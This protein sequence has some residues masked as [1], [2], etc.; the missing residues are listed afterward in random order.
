MPRLIA[1]G[2]KVLSEL[3]S[4]S[5]ELSSLE[6][7]YTAFKTNVTSCDELIPHPFTPLSDNEVM[8]IVQPFSDFTI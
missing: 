3:G 1:C 4:D 7:G 8:G 6:L 5:A 2:A